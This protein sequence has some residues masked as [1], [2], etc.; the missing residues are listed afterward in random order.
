MSTMIT[1][2]EAAKQLG[3]DVAKFHRLVAKHRIDP[4]RKLPGI[5]GAMLWHPDDIAAITEVAQ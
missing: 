3:V 2:A 4:A 5:R 1:T